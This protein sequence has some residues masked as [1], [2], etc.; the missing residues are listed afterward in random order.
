MVIERKNR[1]KEF[2]ACST[3]APLY[4]MKYSL[5]ILCWGLSSKN[6]ATPLTDLTHNNTLEDIK[7]QIY[8]HHFTKAC[9]ATK[10][11]NTLQVSVLDK[12]I[13]GKAQ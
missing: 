5:M 13:F 2:I 1:F 4:S 10:I 8:V 6:G 11:I 3:I 12:V 7:T 9:H